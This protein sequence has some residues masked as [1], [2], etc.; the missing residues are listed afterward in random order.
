LDARDWPKEM[1]AEI[2][3]HVGVAV[4]SLGAVGKRELG[5]KY[6]GNYW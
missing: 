4:D 3:E 1:P 5:A 6:P 2:G